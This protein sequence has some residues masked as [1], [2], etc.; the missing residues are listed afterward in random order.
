MVTP[1]NILN[2]H[3][4]KQTANGEKQFLCIKYYYKF[5]NN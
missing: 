3:S 2:T 1:L 5:I 4:H